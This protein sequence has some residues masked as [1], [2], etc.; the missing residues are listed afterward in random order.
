M[1]A[2][3]ILWVIVLGFMVVW[4]SGCVAAVVAVGAGAAAGTV[5]VQG[6]LQAVVDQE[7]DKVYR[8]GLNTLEQLALPITG[9]DKTALDAKLIG[10]NSEDK[11][12]TI[13]LKR[14]EENYTKISIRVG[15]FGDEAQS[16]AIYD[17]IKENL[18]MAL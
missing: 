11:K 13:K 4:L 9:R 17:K 7:L 8:A 2:K 12:I 14:T 3:K 16:R 10:R 6:D 15:T 5:Y 1:T 18:Q